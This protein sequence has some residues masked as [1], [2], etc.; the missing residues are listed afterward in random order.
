[1][2]KFRYTGSVVESLRARRMRDQ[3]CARS[4]SSWDVWMSFSLGE[5]R[6]RLLDGGTDA[7]DL[8]GG[9]VERLVRCWGAQVL[10]FVPGDRFAK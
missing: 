10:L 2:R 5:V 4:A 9:S 6:T 1:M 8:V 3:R 7:D